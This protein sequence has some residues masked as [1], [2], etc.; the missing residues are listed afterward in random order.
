MVEAFD[1]NVIMC[2]V[3]D[4]YKGKQIPKGKKSVTLRVESTGASFK[5]TK[6]LIRGIGGVLR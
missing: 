1:D 5:K 4:V 3:I 2:S 6:E